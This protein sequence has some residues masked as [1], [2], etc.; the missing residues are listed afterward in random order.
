MMDAVFASSFSKR[1]I[2]LSVGVCLGWGCAAPGAS[3]AKR[4]AGREPVA[5]QLK[6]SE[7]LTP[8]R[9]V[10]PWGGKDSRHAAVS[11]PR[12][13]KVVSDSPQMSPVETETAPP[14]ATQSPPVKTSAAMTGTTLPATATGPSS[15]LED[16]PIGVDDVLQ[17]TIFNIP[18]TEEQVLPRVA[19]VRVSQR[20]VISMPLLGEIPALGMTASVLESDLREKYRKYIRDPQIGVRVTS[21]GKFFVDGAVRKPGSYLFDRAYTLTQALAAAGGVD[22]NLAQNSDI[23][24]FRQNGAQSQAIAF[25]LDKIRSGEMVD[26]QMR[27]GDVVVVFVSAPKYIVDRFLGTLGLGT[28]IP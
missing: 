10:A 22:F 27:S 26:P 8:R 23:T 9:D 24:V 7:H 20:G 11:R 13:Q 19:E 16:Y 12:E 17:V 25:D 14:P 2:A 18:A 15:S 3:P 28:P 6:T 21:G 1:V 5:N 4:L